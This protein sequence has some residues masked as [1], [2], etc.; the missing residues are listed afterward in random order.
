[1]QRRTLPGIIIAAAL[2]SVGLA[3]CGTSQA[4]TRPPLP[5]ATSPA[6]PATPVPT[7]PAPTTTDTP[8]AVT[9][10]QYTDSERAYF[11]QLSTQAPELANASAPD[12]LK[13]GNGVCADLSAGTSPSDEVTALVPI[14]APKGYTQADI[15]VIVQAAAVNLCTD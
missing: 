8:P 6:A 12:M 13:L 5:P 2:L 9:T 11:H 15:Q 10:P 1:M 4:A 7:T 14:G 3:A